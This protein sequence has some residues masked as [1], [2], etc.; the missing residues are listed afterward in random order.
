[1]KGS[2]KANNVEALSMI[3]QDVYMNTAVKNRG[4][5]IEAVQKQIKLQNRLK[6]VMV[7][8]ETKK[9]TEDMSK[10]SNALDSLGV[11]ITSDIEGMIDQ[12]AFLA[13]TTKERKTYIAELNK[14]SVEQ[15]KLAATMAL[16]D[17]KKQTK[18][19]SDYS[20][21]LSK[22]GVSITSDIE[23]MIDQKAFLAMTTEQRKAYIA[24]LK[25]QSVEQTRLAA[26]MALADAKQQTKD[27]S[28][29][30]AALSGLGVVITSDIAGM[31]DQKAFLAMTTEERKAY[32][33][34]LKNQT[35]EEK[36]LNA[37]LKLADIKDG[38]KNLQNQLDVTKKLVGQGIS[39]EIAGL[40]DIELYQNLSTEAK[41]EYL[42]TLQEEM[43]IQKALEFYTKSSQERQLDALNLQNQALDL[44]SSILD[45]KLSGLQRESEM[46][47]RQVSDRNR[48]LDL[49]SREEEK[50]NKVYDERIKALDNV[51][52]ANDR[53]AAKQQNQISLASALASGD[54]AAAATSMSQM[55]ADNAQNQ[56]DDTRAALERQRE[57]DLKN[58][59]I[60]VN[61]VMMTREEIEAS[62]LSISDAIYLKEEEILDV[63]DQLYLKSLDQQKLDKER[64]RLETE[65]TLE[66]TKQAIEAIRATLPVGQALTDLNKMIA[67]YNA[68]ETSAIARYGNTINTPGQAQIFTNFTGG[69]VPSATSKYGIVPGVGGMDSVRMAA[70]PGEFVVR[71]AMVDKYGIPLLESINMGS[72]KMSKMGQPRYKIGNSGKF[73]PKISGA[74]NSETMYNNTYNVNVNVAGTD[75][76]PD[77]IARVVMDKISQV[78]RGNLR[79]SNY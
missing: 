56:I 31:I 1:M 17:A 37:V 54:I 64:L 49:L 61:G 59:K 39:G 38:T 69:K 74:K 41:K 60:D 75:A 35:K 71:K 77:D 42:A 16:A 44:S 20:A 52:K 78:G 18:D 9:A 67:G 43:S 25:K 40:I 7:L 70:T 79:S 15:A 22:V 19:M 26:T 34:E 46:L 8:A 10:Y 23:G 3:P 12:K 6:A 24:E 51:S 50:V 62:I 5:L 58:L 2:A 68:L 27:M 55:T 30:S 29:Y 53:L 66:K 4:K 65:I 63:Q 73:N 47:N 76:S 14:Q 21:A 57:E 45:E 33:A 13:M 72:F 36:E 11:V 28:D 48:A 32:I